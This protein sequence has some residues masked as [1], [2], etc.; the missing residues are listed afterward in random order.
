MKCL[1]FPAYP[2]QW[3]TCLRGKLE[4][5][6]VC[7]ALAA[8]EALGLRRLPTQLPR[9]RIGLQQALD[10]E[11]CAVL[12][13]FSSDGHFLR[14]LA[15]PCSAASMDSDDRTPVYYSWWNSLFQIQWKRV[16]VL[17]AGIK[18]Q[19]QQSTYSLVVGASHNDVLPQGTPS[20][21]FCIPIMR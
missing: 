6:N 2:F 19:Q 3:Y 21:R 18:Q 4:I 12:L 13:G 10:P 9:V 1:A 15:S 17:N 20:D 11:D 16:D 7:W 14:T 5:R 8:R